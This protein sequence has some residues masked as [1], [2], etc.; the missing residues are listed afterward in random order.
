MN[1]Y[2][3]YIDEVGNHDMNSTVVTT[4]HQQFLTLFGVVVEREQMLNVIQP[5]MDTIKRQYFQTDPDDP[6]IFHRKDIVKMTGQFRSLWDAQ[7]RKQ[8]GDAM[9]EAYARWQYATIGVTIDKKAHLMQYGEWHQPPYVYCLQVLMERYVLFLKSKNATGDAMIEA[10]G[11]R[12]DRELDEAYSKFFLAGSGYV[13]ANT[14]QTYL[15]TQHLKINPKR[16][17]IAGLQL[18]DMLAHAAHYHILQEYGYIKAQTAQYGQE[19]TKILQQ[20]KYHRSYQGKIKGLGMK[21]L[22]KRPEGR[23][24]DV[25]LPKRSTH[26]PLRLAD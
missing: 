26:I 1:L 9:L 25:L 17:N 5:E 24:F 6:I 12:E 14:W 23:F 18:A 15:T 19:I 16:D 3:I 21:M 10:R 20:D 11:K 8:F 22:P 2:R 7:K 13:S 4:N